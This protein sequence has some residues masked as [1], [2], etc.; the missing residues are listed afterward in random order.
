MGSSTPQRRAQLHLVKPD[1]PS[2]GELLAAVRAGD[3]KVASAFCARV[4]PTVVQTVRR[5]LGSS[6][7]ELDDVSQLSV[8]AVLSSVSRYRGEGGLDGWVRMVTAHT[9]YKQLRRRGFERKLF[10]HLDA[11]AAEPARIKGPSA[12]TRGR[13]AVKRVVDHLSRLDEEKATAWVLHDVY[14]HDMREIAQI[15]DVSESAAQTRVSRGRRELHERL[16]KDESLK[17]LLDE[18]EGEP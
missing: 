9:V 15:T 6:D 4:W 10:T 17:G 14:G 2:D 7:P 8:M 12:L 18:L 3:E 13:E 11:A 5:L 16:A 1:A